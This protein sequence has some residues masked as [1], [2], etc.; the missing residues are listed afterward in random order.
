MPSEAALADREIARF[1]LR[2][3]AESLT[4]H[5]ERVHEG[6][7]EKGVHETRVQS[8]RMRAAFDAF[9]EY[10]LPGPF[11]QVYQDI[12]RLTRICGK[13]RETAVNCA[14]LVELCRT[15]GLE[16]RFSRQL[17][18]KLRKKLARQEKRLKKE[19][20][21][22]D[23][24]RLSSHLES[25]IPAIEPEFENL[26]ADAGFPQASPRFLHSACDTFVDAAP[27]PE[28]SLKSWFAEA[29]D[30]ELHT[31]RI[32]AKKLRYSLEFLHPFQPGGL[33]P[34]IAK[35]RALQDAGGQFHDWCVLTA[36]LER[37]E[38]HSP[39][40]TAPLVAGALARKIQLREAIR[41]ALLDLRQILLLGR[42]ARRPAM[43][44]AR[45]RKAG[46]P[47]TRATS[48]SARIPR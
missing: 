10:L 40:K 23:V 16:D 11:L 7:T 41:P 2:K 48:R 22:L 39:G 29:S 6:V 20:R 9:R 36:W 12:R 19:L 46:Y 1:V 13:P 33:T 45:G 25:V 24:Q 27:L 32:A 43:L 18:R 42:N 37:N 15:A 3:N 44:L 17:Q 47:G 30:E 5:L 8:R 35:A 31:L 4:G 34:Q 38:I 28:G 26:A 21:A 14:L